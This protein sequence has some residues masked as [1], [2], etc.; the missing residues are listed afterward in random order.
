MT[1]PDTPKGV[2]SEEYFMFD[3]DGNVTDDKTKAV[4]AEVTQTLADGSQR[5]TL[6]KKSPSAGAS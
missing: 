6:M 3:A 4:T 1:K 5:H 2:V